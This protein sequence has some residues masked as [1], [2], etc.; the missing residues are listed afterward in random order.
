MT[1]TR[2]IRTVS[3]ILLLSSSVNTLWRPRP[4]LRSIILFRTDRA[5]RISEPVVVVLVVSHNCCGHSTKHLQTSPGAAGGVVSDCSA[6]LGWRCHSFIL[7]KNFVV[8]EKGPN[9]KKSN[10]DMQTD[11]ITE[12]VSLSSH[13]PSFMVSLCFSEEKK[14]T[15]AW[16]QVWNSLPAE[17][18]L[19]VLTPALPPS[20]SNNNEEASGKR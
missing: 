9:G 2:R 8:C 13:F 14:K 11:H 4:T 3:V 5:L 12:C 16:H 19:T 7:R 10:P 1:I 6:E 18:I 20:V 15:A 17:S